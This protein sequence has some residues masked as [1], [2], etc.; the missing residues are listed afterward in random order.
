VHFLAY[1]PRMLRSLGSDWTTTR[2]RQ[3]P[4]PGLRLGLLVAS[5]VG[6]T[7]LALAVL[8]PITGWHGG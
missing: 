6:G 3:L 7:A 5:I 4:G 8:S 1:V 2:R